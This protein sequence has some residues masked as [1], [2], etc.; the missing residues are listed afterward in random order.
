MV[1]FKNDEVAAF[2]CTKLDGA[3]DLAME[4]TM[5]HNSIAEHF[6]LAL[7]WKLNY[8]ITIYMYKQG[9]E[10]TYNKLNCLVNIKFEPPSQHYEVTWQTR[11]NGSTAML[12]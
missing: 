10:L 5:L 6:Y 8:N 2:L 9:K 1:R 12:L 4:V 11:N 3:I 7:A